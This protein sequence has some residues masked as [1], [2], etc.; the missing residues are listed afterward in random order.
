[1]EKVWLKNYDPGVPATIDYP[2]VTLHQLLEETASPAKPPLS[3]L[4]LWGTPTG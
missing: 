4:V 1:M 3:S 2:K